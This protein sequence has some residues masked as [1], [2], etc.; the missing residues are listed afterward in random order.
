ML[1]GLRERVGMDLP[2][3]AEQ[4]P[5]PS[6]STTGLWQSVWEDESSLTGS[7]RDL[8]IDTCNPEIANLVEDKEIAAHAVAFV[9]NSTRK[10]IVP[11]CS[12]VAK[13]LRSKKWTIVIAQHAVIVLVAQVTAPMEGH[14]SLSPFTNKIHPPM[15]YRH[16]QCTTH[17]KAHPLEYKTITSK[18]PCMDTREED[19]CRK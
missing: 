6:E 17:T 2:S 9:I 15:A 14:L 11:L 5:L 12:D 3:S 1:D 13:L 4:S 7:I 8:R 16:S 19:H 18:L 10:G